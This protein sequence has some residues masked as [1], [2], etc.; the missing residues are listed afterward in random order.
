MKKETALFIAMFLYFFSLPVK[1]SV[2]LKLSSPLQLKTSYAPGSP[3]LVTQIPN[4][5]H[6]SIS[7]NAMTSLKDGLFFGAIDLY[8][9]GPTFLSGTWEKDGMTDVSYFVT[10]IKLIRSRS[11][12]PINIRFPS[13]VQKSV[14]EAD[15]AQKNIERQDINKAIE[16]TGG[17]LSDFCWGFPVNSKVVS[18]FGSYRTA[19]AGKTYYHGGVDL[20]AITGTPVYASS[21]GIVTLAQTMIV[22]GKIVTINHGAGI[23]SMYMHLSEIKIKTGDRV[24]KG[25]LIALSGGTGRAEA[26]HLHW[27]VRWRGISLDPLELRRALEPFCD[28]K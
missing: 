17:I 12:Q 5:Q 15:E 13:S 14:F 27:E 25:Q 1:T 11:P 2:G 3:L 4:V 6:Y 7:G 8:Y 23:H 20:R 24:K 28:P 26:P 19:K 18:K 21:E 9:E 16:S 10:P 22:P